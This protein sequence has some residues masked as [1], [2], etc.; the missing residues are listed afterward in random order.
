MDSSCEV[1]KLSLK[2]N[3]VD[4]DDHDELLHSL[5]KQ[6]GWGAYDIILFFQNFWIV[7]IYL[8]AT[9]SF[10]KHF[11]AKHNDILIVS[12]P[13]S[14]TTWLKVLAFA[15]AKRS[16][17]IPSQ[18]NNHPL[19]CSNPHT[20]VPFFEMDIYANNPN[21]I[22]PSNLPEPRMF[23]THLPFPSLVSSIIHNNSNCKII[24]ICRSPFDTFIS[25]WHF[26][27]NILPPSAPTL[28][29]NDALERYC[30]GVVPFGPFWSH[31][32]SY[33]KAGNDTPNK[34]LFMKYEDLK[35]NT[36]F[37]L[38]RMAQFLNYPFSEEEESGG[39]I[40]SIIELCSFG[41]MKE[42]EVNKSGKISLR[43]EVVNKY[44]F[45]N[46][47]TGDWVN[48]FSPQMT[49]KLSKVIEE[50]FGGS[51]TDLSV[52]MPSSKPSAMIFLL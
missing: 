12:L 46:G 3:N 37:E 38:K 23:G 33:W 9:L 45:R 19:H 48:Y 21:N 14:G 34:V 17:F 39:V 36:K 20:L 40:D 47:E 8:K 41:K 52:R 22:D 43:S 30:E 31:I 42:M 10:Q 44:F 29:L 4:D 27:N 24:Y 18:I 51:D 26:F 7:P 32:L 1:E 11:Q 2:G 25:Y 28:P 50:K 16:R 35:A 5:P 15:T 49:E 13:K 6:K